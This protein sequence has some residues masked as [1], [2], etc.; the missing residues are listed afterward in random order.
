MWKCLKIRILKICEGYRNF[1]YLKMFPYNF[2][3]FLHY[4]INFLTF[5]IWSI[6]WNF[7]IICTI[8]WHYF[9]IWPILWHFNI[10]S[11]SW[12]FCIF[13]QFSVILTLFGQFSVIFILFGQFSDNFTLFCKFSDIKHYL[14]NYLT[15]LHF[16]QVIYRHFFTSTRKI[17]SDIF[18]HSLLHLRRIVRHFFWQFT[19][20]EY[21]Q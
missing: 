6:L 16:D 12:Y 14:A 10:W 8:I 13:S 5:Y 7:C 21:P 1:W 18:T 2:L 3:T 11:I 20:N 15:S 4:L 9:T 19:E 17:F